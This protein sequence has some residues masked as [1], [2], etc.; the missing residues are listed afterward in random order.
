LKETGKLINTRRGSERRQK[1]QKHLTSVCALEPKKPRFSGDT[2]DLRPTQ[3]WEKLPPN[4]IAKKEKETSKRKKEKRK[5]HKNP[6][7]AN[8]V[9]KTVQRRPKRRFNIHHRGNNNQ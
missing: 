9:E 2:E 5:N 8:P 4:R 7:F 1:K 6:L 3:K